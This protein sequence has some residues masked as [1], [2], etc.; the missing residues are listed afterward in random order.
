MP[1]TPE[2]TDAVM[3]ELWT[4]LTTGRSDVSRRGW[5]AAAGW[6]VPAVVAVTSPPAFAAS[7]DRL[8]ALVLPQVRVT[9]AGRSPISPTVTG[10]DGVPFAS[11][12]VSVSG[13]SGSS[14]I[15]SVEPLTQMAIF[16]GPSIRAPHGRRRDPG[17]RSPS[18]RGA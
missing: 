3:H 7:V 9:A 1:H 13:L 17:P 15:P 10:P 2:A 12:T 6:S 14:F 8:V 4:R 11:T 16:R 5:P 18:S